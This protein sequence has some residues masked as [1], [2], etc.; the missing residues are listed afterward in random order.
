VRSL[1]ALLLVL[2]GA[3]AALAEDGSTRLPFTPFR[4]AREGDYSVVAIE[5]RT[6]TA[7]V[8]AVASGS[9]TVARDGKNEVVSTAEAP[10][11]AQ[12]FGR[13]EKARITAWRV[14]DDTLDLGGLVVACQRLT[15]SVRAKGEHASVSVFFSKDVKG[16][17]VAVV[18]VRQLEPQATTDEETL[19]EFGTKNG[20][21]WK[22]AP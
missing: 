18:K 6:T 4:D 5:T 20:A 9:V 17:G 14:I 10:T 7:R 22:K 16:S 21:S 12:F 2:G 11:V 15:F 1:L 8:V 3:L 19:V 13:W